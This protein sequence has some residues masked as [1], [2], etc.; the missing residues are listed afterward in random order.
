VAMK[1]HKKEKKE[2]LKVKL[3]KPIVAIN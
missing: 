1:K 2:N 3:T